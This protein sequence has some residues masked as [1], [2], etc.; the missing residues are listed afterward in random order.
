MHPVFESS[1]L[2]S[3]PM[4]APNSE[5][6]DAKR[7]APR[8]GAAGHRRERTNHEHYMAHSRRQDWT[9]PWRRF[10]CPT[11]IRNDSERCEFILPGGSAHIDYLAHTGSQRLNELLALLVADELDCDELDWPRR[12]V[13]SSRAT[14]QF[15]LSLLAAHSLKLRAGGATFESKSNT[16][17]AAGSLLRV[18][19]SPLL[20]IG[21]DDAADLSAVH[22]EVHMNGREFA[23]GR[24]DRVTERA[25]SAATTRERHAGRVEARQTAPEAPPLSPCRARGPRAACLCRETWSWSATS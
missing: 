2:T 18:A 3:T 10:Y 7:R 20:E 17:K 6:R 15:P 1:E 5:N 9:N 12:G 24:R 8:W 13:G 19:L 4:V 11:R 23:C 21:E 16:C 25:H 22:L 14:G